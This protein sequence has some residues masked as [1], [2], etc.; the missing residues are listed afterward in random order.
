MFTTLV[1][2]ILAL[3]VIGLIVYLI[4]T[5]IPGAAAFKTIIR[6]VVAIMLIIWLVYYFGPDIDKALTR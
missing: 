3:A 6:V 2:L 4:E 1:Y 5:Q